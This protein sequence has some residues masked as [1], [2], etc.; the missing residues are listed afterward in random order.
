M[1]KSNDPFIYEVQITLAGC[2]D[3]S[4]KRLPGAFFFGQ[5]TQCL[6]FGLIILHFRRMS[7]LSS[8]IHITDNVREK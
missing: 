1:S 3:I 4:A 2:Y 8:N 6:L 7:G 5:Y